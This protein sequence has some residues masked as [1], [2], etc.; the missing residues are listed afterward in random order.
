MQK[1][2]FLPDVP[3]VDITNLELL[4]KLISDNNIDAIINCAA[5][6]AVDKSESEEALARKINADGPRNLA[7]AAKKANAKLVHVSTDYVFNGKNN[8]PLKEEDATDPIGVYGKT[9][10]EGEIAV[11]ERACNSIVIRTAWLYS[12][13]CNNFVKTM[14]QIGRAHV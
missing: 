6:T 13:F 14:I 2:L 12:E 7:I 5:Y 8:L 9:K 1:H 10:R 4:E 3:E 11:E